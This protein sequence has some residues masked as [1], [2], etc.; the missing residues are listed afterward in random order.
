MKDQMFDKLRH[1]A[2]VCGLTAALSLPGVAMAG[3]ATGADACVVVLDCSDGQKL[4]ATPDAS[5]RFVLSKVPPGSCQL[6]VVPSDA[7][8]VLQPAADESRLLPTVNK[9][10][11]VDAALVKSNN[12]TAREAGSGMTTGKRQYRPMVFRITLDDFPAA[13]KTQAL[14]DWSKAPVSIV[15]DQKA[16]TR[17]LTGHDTLIK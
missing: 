8:A 1:T 9:V 5:G 6:R 10:T 12:A 11:D 15:V 17:E 14:D 7:K 3:P 16:K 13:A 2:I 4:T